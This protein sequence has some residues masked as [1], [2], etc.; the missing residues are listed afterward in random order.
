MCLWDQL[1]VTQRERKMCRVVD[2]LDFGH[3]IVCLRVVWSRHDTTH[4]CRAVSKLG[5]ARILHS[6]WLNSA[7]T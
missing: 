1:I 6:L 4:G 7:M 5:T 2:F 3:R